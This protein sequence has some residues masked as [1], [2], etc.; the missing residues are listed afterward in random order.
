MTTATEAVGIAAMAMTAASICLMMSG[1]TCSVIWP[2]ILILKSLCVPMP[3]AGAGVV[4]EA[5]VKITGEETTAIEETNAFMVI[6]ATMEGVMDPIDRIMAHT[7][8]QALMAR[9]HPLLHTVSLPDL[10]HR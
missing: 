8:S 4:V 5:E 7:G 10:D 1:A 6:I 3:K 9:R 2:V